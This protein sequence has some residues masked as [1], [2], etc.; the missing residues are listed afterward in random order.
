M[1]YSATV[2]HL[3][4]KIKVMALT[5]TI[6]IKEQNIRPIEDL[7]ILELPPIVKNGNLGKYIFLYDFQTTI[8]SEEAH[9]IM[10]ISSVG[11]AFN[12]PKGSFFDLKY[13]K[14]D[15]INVVDFGK[16]IN[17]KGALEVDRNKL[18]VNVPIYVKP[19]IKPTPVNDSV[20]MAEMN[21]SFLPTVTIDNSFNTLQKV[22]ESTPITTKFGV[23]FGK[24]PNPKT[25]PVLDN[26]VT[27][28][29]NPTPTG[30]TTTPVVTNG[31]QNTEETKG[32]FDDKNN[33][34]M[35]GVILLVGYLLLDN[36]AE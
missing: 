22:A 30:T 4:K 18:I 33:L 27:P 36:K 5:K 31:V 24:N 15:I 21:K 3:I 35:V 25:Q 19:I 12:L 13:S 23:G 14:G 1:L 11:G 16:T 26:P 32:F 29:P 17:N 34:I 28:N 8:Y 2:N 10:K 20:A 7:E 6:L 9:N